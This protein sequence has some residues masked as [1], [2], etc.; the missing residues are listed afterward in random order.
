V[1]RA[2]IIAVLFRDSVEIKKFYARYGVIS[3]LPDEWLGQGLTG[4][5]TFGDDNAIC[6]C[7]PDYYRHDAVIGV[8]WIVQRPS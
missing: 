8:T 3:D 7:L 2:D 5:R 1:G 4:S 6:T